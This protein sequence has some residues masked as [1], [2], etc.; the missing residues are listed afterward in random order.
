M[1]EAVDRIAKW[2]E[3]IEKYSAVE[4]DRLPEIYLYMDQVLTYMNK[5]IGVFERSENT[6]LLTSSMINN[7]VKDGIL[8]RPEQKKY[9]REHLALLLVI[10]MLKQVLSIQDISFL[11]KTLLENTGKKEMYGQF[12]NA[13]SAALKEVCE[14]VAQTAGQGDAELTKLAI[15]LSIEATARRT[16]SERI[17][18]EL[19][20]AEE[21]ARKEREEKEK[22]GKK[23]K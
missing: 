4:W 3:Q 16:V 15:E 8:P 6:S 20:T 13:H 21:K 10:C 7:Y 14:R 11:L 19:S 22:G 2:A 9:S 18:S 12:C 17:L 23:E 1:S 5:Q